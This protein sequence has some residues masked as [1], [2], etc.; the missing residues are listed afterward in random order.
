MIDFSPLSTNFFPFACTSLQL[1]LQLFLRRPP[2][3]FTFNN[4]KFLKKSEEKWN[5]RLQSILKG[6]LLLNMKSNLNN[7]MKFQKTI[8]LNSFAYSL[9]VN[10]QTP[11]PIRG[12]WME[13]EC[14][15]MGRFAGIRNKE[16]ILWTQK[17]G[18]KDVHFIE[19]PSNFLPSFPSSNSSSRL[20]EMVDAI[21]LPLF[22]LA[23]GVALLLLT[24]IY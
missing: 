10:G 4:L 5:E 3:L 20:V 19:A 24:L 15:I 18:V 22:A 17:G 6:C 14:G 13:S 1:F 7:S 2:K 9:I 12:Q 11:R 16:I 23:G 8:F 21:S